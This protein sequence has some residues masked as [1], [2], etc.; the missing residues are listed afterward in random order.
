MYEKKRQLIRVEQRVGRRIRRR[1]CLPFTNA[2]TQPQQRAAELESGLLRRGVMRVRKV[3]VCQA[4]RLGQQGLQVEGQ[5]LRSREKVEGGGGAEHGERG[6][7]R[8]S[9]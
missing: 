2:P 4:L 9:M 8:L 6:Q 5:H 7:V 3:G 1:G